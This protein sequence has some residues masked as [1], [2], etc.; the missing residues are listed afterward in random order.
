MKLQV[1]R[2]I[3]FAGLLL[4]VAA[5]AK[6]EV[7]P[8]CFAG[9]LSFTCAVNRVD[10]AKD[11]D[12]LAK[13]IFERRGWDWACYEVQY[14]RGDDG[15]PDTIMVSVNGIRGGRPPTCGA[16]LDQGARGAMAGQELQAVARELKAA[17][18]S[19]PAPLRAELLRK[20]KKLAVTNGFGAVAE[21][22]L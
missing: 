18:S 9:T 20:V 15:R 3:H 14:I 21:T 8:D 16:R 11:V 6:A 4:L 2:G 5:P 10:E 19:A 7:S 22:S 13:P 1:M 17:I 12:K